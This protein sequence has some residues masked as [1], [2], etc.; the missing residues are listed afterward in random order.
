[1][2]FSS[3]A[4][5]E[6]CRT[7]FGGG[8]CARA[9]LYGVLLHCNTFTPQEVRVITESGDFAER[10][11]GL[12]DRAFGVRFD[13]LP[14]EGEQKYIFQITEM[15][16]ISRMIDAFGFDSRQSPVLHINF[17]LLEEECCRA[18][19]L[20]GAFL[21][22]GSIT[23]PSKRYHLE[24]VTSHA[25]ASRELAALLT[26]MGR[27]PR[28]TARSGCQVTYFKSSGQI[29][30]LLT[31]MGAPRSALELKNTR[32]EK[33]LRNGV[34]RRVNCEAA[35]LDKAVDAAQEQLLAIRRLYELDRVEGL[36]AQLKETIIL[37]E[38]YP[39]LTLSQLAEEFDPPI[40]K[41]GLNHRL[42]KLVE[43]SKQ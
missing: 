6:L 13:R 8:C 20:R 5:A 14:G 41:S 24:L 40:T 26:D 19:F 29:E 21:A 10:L 30:E 28:Q 37:R 7:G 3:E 39:E 38:T 43:L 35:N 27:Q 1:M 42:R 34:N 33:Q 4:K 18:A 31:V 12:L 25:Q 32:A 2:S 36:S 16:K 17:G 11:P 23:E 15:E 9:E 22:G